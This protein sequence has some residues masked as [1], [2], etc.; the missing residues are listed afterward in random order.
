MIDNG[1]GEEAGH[2]GGEGGGHGGGE[3][4]GHGGGEN[5]VD[6]IQQSSL[7]LSSIMLDPHVQA[8][9]RKEMSTERATSGEEAKL[10]QLVVDLTTPLYDGLQS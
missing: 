4:A 6:S 9:L 1:G 3:G 8:F 5:D 7:V 10:E 2:G